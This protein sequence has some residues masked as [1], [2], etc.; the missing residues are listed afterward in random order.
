M[1]ADKTT[2][3]T[4]PVNIFT[5]RPYTKFYTSSPSSRLVCAI[6]LKVKLKFSHSCKVVLH[7]TKLTLRKAAYFFKEPL[8]QCFIDLYWVV[9]VSHLTYKPVCLPCFHYWL[10]ISYKYMTGVVCIGINIV[11]VSWF[12]SWK[13]RVPIYSIC[14]ANYM[15][16]VFRWW[17][18]H[19]S[20]EACVS[21]HL[22]SRYFVFR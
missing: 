18:H 20:S 12:N 11:T 6:Q 16:C 15:C 2:F 22:P 9:T 1:M 21:Q 3:L 17:T 8:P 13:D 14:T 10:Y 19:A 5:I 7:C 4:Q